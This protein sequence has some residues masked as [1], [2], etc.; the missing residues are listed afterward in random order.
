M[1]DVTQQDFKEKVLFNERLV[2]VDFWAPWCG[3]CKMIAPVLEQVAKD[4]DGVVEVLK[5]NVDE[6]GELAQKYK[7]L[8]IPTVLLFKEGEAVDGCI[9]IRSRDY[10]DNLIEKYQK[11]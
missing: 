3:P 7:I 8:S 10:F 4:H 2:L 11:A 6:N 1:S 5:L 9:G